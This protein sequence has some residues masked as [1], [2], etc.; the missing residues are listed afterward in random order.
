MNKIS[1]FQ[2]EQPGREWLP[3]MQRL[4]QALL[5]DEHV[6]LGVTAD[7]QELAVANAEAA[8]ASG[9]LPLFLHQAGETMAEAF[10]RRP[11]MLWR[12]DSKAWCSA[13][14][15][16]G[17]PTASM[18]VWMLFISHALDSLKHQQAD[19]VRQNRPLLVDDWVNRWSQAWR[20]GRLKFQTSGA[21]TSGMPSTTIRTA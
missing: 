21:A 12:A 9:F 1:S 14:P 6:S 2:A 11:S 18:G 19:R 16:P 8:S 5:D 17:E 20:G 10:G 3:R 4:V 15:D 13:V 7:G